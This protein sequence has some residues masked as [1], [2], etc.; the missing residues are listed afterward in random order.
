MAP[1]ADAD[2]FYSV[3]E[4]AN[5]AD[6]AAIKA[7]YKRLAKLR[8]PDRN[9]GDAQATANFQLLQVAYSTLS[10]PSK[11]A[12]YDLQRSQ[13]NAG[14]YATYG[15]AGPSTANSPGPQSSNRHAKQA[16]AATEK[17]NRELND[18]RQAR[19]SLSNNYAQEFELAAKARDALRGLDEQ[20]KRDERE[21]AESQSWSTYLASFVDSAA[22]AADEQ[23]RVMRERRAIQ[24]LH[25]REF[26]ERDLAR[27]EENLKSLSQRLADTT[28][29]I[30]ATQLSIS[31]LQREQKKEEARKPEEPSM[32]PRRQRDDSVREQM[33]REAEA[34]R[35]ME[36]M[37]RQEA[38]Q[39]RAK[40]REVEEERRRLKKEAEQQAEER[41]RSHRVAEEGRR[42]Q[43]D[44]E[45]RASKERIRAQRDAQERWRLQKEGEERVSTERSRV[46]RDA[47]E[48]WRL[49][50]EAE[51]RASKERN[52][53]QRAAEEG[54]RLQK[55]FEDRQRQ[56]KAAEAGKRLQRAAEEI[57]HKRVSEEF[58][59]ATGRKQEASRQNS[60]APREPDTIKSFQGGFGRALVAREEDFKTIW[61]FSK[62]HGRYVGDTLLPVAQKGKAICD[63]ELICE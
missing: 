41:V 63:V 19:K 39:R 12:A 9:I 40:Q 43:R 32:E 48:R 24:R 53:V 27:C 18:Y 20:A 36:T 28:R 37:R 6:L 47:Q 26:R 46:Q 4:V 38:D 35:E 57:R 21:E 50:K 42:L 23:A 54:M 29:R 17:L 1:L 61:M 3:L 14:S 58:S 30:N 33:R 56:E 13:T 7:S 62:S 51:E 60:T 8:H 45:E 44:A 5:R 15:G 34:F 55:A 59:G 10:D 49:Q 22:A 52:R 2:D 25:A 16:H 31:Q 11:R